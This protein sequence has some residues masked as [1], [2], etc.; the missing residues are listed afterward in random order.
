MNR[1]ARRQLAQQIN[2]GDTRAALAAMGIDHREVG[3]MF[4]R[5]AQGQRRTAPT[6]TPDDVDSITVPETPA[7]FEQAMGDE[8]LMVRIF[9]NG[10]TGAQ[11][12]R[13]YAR[14]VMDRDQRLGQQ[15]EQLVQAT[16]ADW[17]RE[18]DESGEQPFRR[19]DLGVPD[20]YRNIGSP[21]NAYRGAGLFNP[22]AMGAAIDREFNGSADYFR[23]I[24]HNSQRDAS[25]QARL[26][27]IRNAF[28]STVPSEGGFL[29]PE[30]LRSELLRVALETS[31]IRPRARVIPMESL[32]VPFPAIDETSHA[33]T[34]YGGI[35]AYWTAEGA[36]LTASSP[37]FGRVVLEASKLTMYTEVPNELI[38]DSAISFQAF[39][40]QIFPEALGFYED[41]A[42]INGNGVGQPL[43]ILKGG[44][45][46]SITKE[47]SQ[48]AATI[49]WN[50]IIKMFSRM[51]PNSL[52]RAIWLASIDTFP[53]LAT[54]AL[55]V[56]TGGG[57]VWL[58][59]GVSGPPMTILGRPVYFTE[60]VPKL[61]TTGDIAF[62]DPGMYLIGDRQVMSA[63]SSPHYKFGND[64]TAFRITS[65]VDGRPWMQSAITPKN[66]GPTLSPTVTIATRA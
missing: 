54:M 32:R 22:T 31:L 66:S 63:T 44:N 50:N 29:I 52:G 41:D 47:T 30:V 11:F 56:G 26:S 8:R 12:V 45:V 5:A 62:V 65:R 6:P 9:S 53:E 39:L 40:D 36:A 23:A 51:L 42:F 4:N 57:P 7:E 37:S 64:M 34:V 15:V 25:M 43:G 33:S 61:G 60:K 1:L 16:L 28:S 3:K 10:E 27:R 21:G 35:T 59:N 13:N 49:V 2:T 20:D 38:S 58:S 14:T 55:T 19:I 24:W 46:I 17:R 48:V 18:L